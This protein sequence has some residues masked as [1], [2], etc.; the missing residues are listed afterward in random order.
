M[1]VT[2]KHRVDVSEGPAPGILI[3]TPKLIADDGSEAAVGQ[4]VPLAAGQSL[5]FGPFTMT[6]QVPQSWTTGPTPGAP[7]GAAGSASNPIKV[8]GPVTPAKK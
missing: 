3:A 8:A 6:I 1:I 7:P 5:T 4:P 2:L